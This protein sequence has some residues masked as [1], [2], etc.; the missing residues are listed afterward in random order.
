MKQ[1]LYRIATGR[2]ALICMVLYVLMISQVMNRA[3]QRMEEHSGGTG[4]VD[5][6]IFYKPQEALDM[7]GRYDAETIDFYRRFIF[8]G[9]LV[10]PIIYTFFWGLSTL[11][12]F[13]KAFP[14]GHFMHKLWFVPFVPFWFDMLENAL[15]YQMLHTYPNDVAQLA[16]AASVASGL[17]W[18]SA[19]CAIGLMLTGLGAW[20]WSVTVGRRT[21]K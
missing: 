16:Q 21:S 9:D 7:I 5:L 11:F 6:A 14:E 15:L 12:F 10:Y 2:N 13:K 19:F 20:I 3:Q 4:P 18:I 8:T 17:K 1:F